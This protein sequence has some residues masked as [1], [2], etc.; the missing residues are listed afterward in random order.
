[1]RTNS[2]TER[3]RLIPRTLIA[4]WVL[5]VG[6][7]IALR[8]VLDTGDVG[9]ANVATR[10][11]L[12]LTAI[13]SLIWFLVRG[14]LPLRR[15]FGVLAVLLLGIAAFFG[16]FRYE[17]VRSEIIPI[18]SFRFGGEAPAMATV[19]TDARADLSATTAADFP[20]FLGSGR[21]LRVDGVA[22]ARDW[23][24]QAPELLW[25]EGIGAGWS[26]LAV[27]NGY[28]ATLEEREGT[29]MLTLYDIS[30]GTLVWNLELGPGFDHPM[31]G[32]GPRSTPT[33]FDGI[34]YA[35]GV[36]GAVVAVNGADGSVLWQRDLLQDYGISQDE[37][38]LDV[39]YGRSASPLIVGDA[40]VLPVGG[41]RRQRVSLAAY[42]R[43]TGDRLWEGGAHNVSMSSP[44]LGT[45]LGRQQILI[46]NENWVS[47]HDAQSG[48]Q[49]WE[50]EWPGITSADSSVSQ[51]VALPPDRVF[52]SKGYGTGAALYR[53]EQTGDTIEPRQLWQKPASLRTKLTNVVIRDGY[54]YGLSEGILECVRLDTG[55]REWKAGR[56]HHGQI[57][58]VDDV[59]LVLTEDGEL[60]M[61]E[62][63]PERRNSVLGRFQAIDGHTWNNFALYGDVLLARNG[64][65]IAAWRLP[66]R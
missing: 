35:A 9:L 7:L 36:T 38:T 33:I 6:F 27:V 46:V 53:L 5:V 20:Q 29:E 47:G 14:P 61:V 16:L 59:L 25:R 37:E 3:R 19:A 56:Y 40:V 65:E 57:L 41:S 17:G 44:A 1:M 48:E 50:F 31:G 58:L 42:D 49:L 13:I 32:A 54:V 21:D 11:L 10:A 39:S 24:T 51:A 12:L 28:A 60:V 45:L 4:L 2:A 26:G 63:T 55:E 8:F 66:L 22:L 62:A 23:E 34:V 64:Q 43:M 30:D 15:R 52:V 18:F